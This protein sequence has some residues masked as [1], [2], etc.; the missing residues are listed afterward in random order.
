MR[1]VILERPRAK[2]SYLKKYIKL[3]ESMVGKEAKLEAAKEALFVLY[4]SVVA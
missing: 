2:I 3:L 4:R 1:Y